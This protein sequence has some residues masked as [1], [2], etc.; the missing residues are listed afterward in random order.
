LEVNPK[1][2]KEAAA[3]HSAT[4]LLHLA[5][6]E[7]LGDRVR[8]AGSLVTPER[9]RFDY[10]QPK[11][12]SALEL[13][14]IE[15][16]VN[17]EIAANWQ[18]TTAVYDYDEAVRSGAM[19]LFEERY[20]DKVR[21]VSM[22]PSRELCGG[23][24]VQRTGD[25]GFFLIAQE[26]PVAAGVRRLECLTGALAVMEF[27]LNRERL[28]ELSQIFKA[29]PGEIASRAIKQAEKLQELARA[30][31]E[32]ADSSFGFE[33]A[34]AKVEEIGGIRLLALI[35]PDSDPKALRDLGDKF[36]DKLKAPA[37][38]GLAAKSPDQKASLLVTVTEDLVDKLPAGRLIGPMA[39]A[40]GGKGGGKS[41]LA[42][43]GGPDAGNLEKALSAFKEEAVKLLGLS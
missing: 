42:Q 9:L 2:R 26:S 4:H 34:L 19:A 14:Q 3:N 39:A 28:R 32:A 5:L 16:R 11:A 23:T 20:G 18:V 7:V 41:R 24:H 30:G 25:I 31:R 21:V 15:L 27:Q 22:G 10:T 6:R 17:A 40:V 12:L 33:E 29:P 1:R 36:R 43:A 38:V 13:S 35:A 8:Q 37:A